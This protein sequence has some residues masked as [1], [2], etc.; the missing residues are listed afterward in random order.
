[1]L[2]FVKKLEPVGVVVAM[3]FPFASAA[4]KVPA[5]VASGVSVMFPVP[6][7]FIEPRP[8]AFIVVVA[9]PPNQLVPVKDARE[10]EAFVNDCRTLQAFECAR[11]RV[12]VIVPLV[13]TGVEPIVRVLLLSERPTEVT[14]PEPPLPMHVPA[15]AKHPAARFMPP[16]EEKVEVPVEKLMP[17]VFPME[18]R[19]PGVV[20]PMPTLPPERMSKSVVVAVPAVE[21]PTAKR[22]E[23]GCE[24]YEPPAKRFKRASGVV[25]PMPILPATRVPV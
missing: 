10:V 2:E 22:V 5:A 15:I 18:S 20:E 19:E 23:A 14:V 17:L 16:V 13:V 25:V 12:A 8:S 7:I 9:V 24:A 21:E 6:D 11:F 3:S 1:M 4:M